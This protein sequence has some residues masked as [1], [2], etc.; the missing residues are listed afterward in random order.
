VAK[1]SICV[2]VLQRGSSH[3]KLGIYD[4]CTDGITTGYGHDPTHGW[5]QN[6][7]LQHTTSTSKSGVS[8]NPLLIRYAVLPEAA[9][10]SGSAAL[11]DIA[12]LIDH[13]TNKYV[14]TIRKR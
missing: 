4:A 8:A 14:I 3:D 10:Y 12:V 1:Y 5:Y 2:F 7:V 6:G 9:V 11:G 13:N